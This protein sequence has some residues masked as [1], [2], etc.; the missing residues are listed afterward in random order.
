MCISVCFQIPFKIGRFLQSARIYFFFLSVNPNLSQYI[1]GQFQ[2]NS[3][4]IGVSSFYT[5][6]SVQIIR[7]SS[8]FCMHCPYFKTPSRDCPKVVLIKAFL[9]SHRDYQDKKAFLQIAYHCTEVPGM[10]KVYNVQ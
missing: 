7:P 2:S 3:M 6:I 1:R 8:K 10:Y 4:V 5:N 9:D